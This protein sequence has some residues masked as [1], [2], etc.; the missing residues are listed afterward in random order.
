MG[1]LKHVGSSFGLGKEILGI[2]LISVVSVLEYLLCSVT[3]V[4]D[5]GTIRRRFQTE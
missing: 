3:C 2:K 1:G 5:W 4:F